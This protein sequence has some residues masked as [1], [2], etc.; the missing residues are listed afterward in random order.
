MHLSA[1]ADIKLEK[2]PGHLRT[3]YNFQDVRSF[4]VDS[5][6]YWI[7]SNSKSNP[8]FEIRSQNQIEVYYDSCAAENSRQSWI[9]SEILGIK[10]CYYVKLPRGLSLWNFWL[11]GPIAFGVTS[12]KLD[13]AMK[14]FVLDIETEETEETSSIKLTWDAPGSTKNRRVVLSGSY[15]DS[16]TYEAKIDLEFPSRHSPLALKATLHDTEDQ[17]GI[18]ATF[19][20]GSE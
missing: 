5:R 14:G 3:E 4:E 11:N 20:R 1:A 10:Y 19:K 17:K 16:P 13:P 12:E 9:S 2:R 18:S 15:S 8:K 7:G 6:L